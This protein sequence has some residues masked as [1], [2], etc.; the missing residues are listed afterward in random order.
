MLKARPLPEA[1]AV[2]RN[3]TILVL[4]SRCEGLGRVLIEGMA[5]GIP[6]IG[7]DVGGIPFMIRDGENGLVFPGG[8]SARFWR[9]ACESFCRTAMSAGE[10]GKTA[11]N[12]RTRS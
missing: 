12:G 3:A 2:I 9:P 10:W 11:M 7:S 4:P 6:L 5:A 1:L 8:D